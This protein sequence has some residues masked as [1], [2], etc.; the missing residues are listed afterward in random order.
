MC[1]YGNNFIK[2]SI[3]Q[4]FVYCQFQKYPITHRVGIRPTLFYSIPE[5]IKTPKLPTKLGG[6]GLDKTGKGVLNYG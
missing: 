3:N 5:E 6:W 4:S 2:N 1:L